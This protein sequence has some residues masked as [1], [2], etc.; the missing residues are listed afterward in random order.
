[1]VDSFLPRRETSATGGLGW[2]WSGRERPFLKMHLP[3]W[4]VG[5]R[6]SLHLFSVKTSLVVG[7]EAGTSG[8]GPGGIEATVFRLVPH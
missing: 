1:M 2:D 5:H 4:L 6:H 7:P 8:G 3:T